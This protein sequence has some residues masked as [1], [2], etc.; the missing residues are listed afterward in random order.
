MGVGVAAG[1]TLSAQLQNR[2]PNHQVI[3]GGTFGY[4][5][6]QILLRYKE[7]LTQQT[8]KTSH[9]IYLFPQFHEVRAVAPPAQLWRLALASTSR[10]A[11]MPYCLLNEHGSLEFHQPERFNINF[12]KG[13]SFSAII[14]TAYDLYFSLKSADRMKQ[15]QGVASALLEEMVK[16]SEAHNVKFTV[17]LV[18]HTPESEEYYSTLLT[19]LNA[20]VITSRPDTLVQSSL[21]AD[22]SH[23][24][25]L[26][27]KYWAD[28]I[29]AKLFP[30]S[31][32]SYHTDGQQFAMQKLKHAL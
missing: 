28:L 16:V 10:S 23:P 18:G 19:S 8:S 27:Q 2:L 30:S 21:A 24:G 14:A 11:M 6:Q 31:S 12:A 17:L 7:L 32:P 5:P 22:N 20:T 1:D 4:G 25:P 26:F 3:N 9:A 15:R 13:A 29:M